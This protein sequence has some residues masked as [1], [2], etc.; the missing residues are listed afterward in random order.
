VTEAQLRVLVAVA[1]AGGFSS[2]AV[3][4]EMSQPGVSR[5]VA[6]LEEELGVQ[7]LVR[8]PGRVSLTNVGARVAAHAREVLARTEAMRQEAGTVSGGY[9]GR[10]RV[11]SLPGLS[12]RL[13]SPLLGRFCAEHPAVEVV[14]SE[15]TDDV[16]LSWIRNHSVDVGVVVRP[17]DDIDVEV[18]GQTPVVAV[19]ADTHPLAGRA[20]V[21]LADLDAERLIVARSGFER[22]I[23]DVFAAEGR[24]PQVAMDVR[25]VA[26]ALS[27][28]AHGLG[29]T[30]VPEE[31]ARPLP[32]RLVARPLDPP[33][34]LDLGLGVKSQADAAPLA[35]A[36]LEA[37][38][39]GENVAA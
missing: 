20:A 34:V 18:I 13:L 11:G 22:L 31:L 19:L 38:A 37:A 27:L 30:V 25:E 26:A 36:F 23:A 17:A 8:A 21:R 4:L 14:L 24:V 39:E 15:S 10:L 28:V 32:S 16:V 9:S 12:G 2:A 35:A 3:R 33:V 7:L 6:N 1:E 5:A 29:V